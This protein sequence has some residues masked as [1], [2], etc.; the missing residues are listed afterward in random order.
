MNNMPYPYIPPQFMPEQPP[1]LQIQ[2]ELMKIKYEIARLKERVSALEGKEHN[3]YLKKD[4][5][6]YMM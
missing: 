6:F 1:K 2:E 5:S 4:D 3:D